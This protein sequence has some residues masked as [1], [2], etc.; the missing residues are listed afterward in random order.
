MRPLLLCA[1]LLALCAAPALAQGRRRTAAEPSAA[2]RRPASRVVPART[3]PA[4]EVPEFE[5]ECPLRD[6]VFADAFQCD[7]YYEC[8]DYVITE[9]LCPD[10]LVFNDISPTLGR[11]DQ[12]FS[13]NCTGREE[14]QEAQPTGDCPRQ[15]G[16]YA[17]PDPTNCGTF[18][19]CV[20]GVSNRV[21]CPSGLV[22]SLQM[23]TC[24]W[25]DQ[26]GRTGCSSAEV[27]AFECPG[28]GDP[29]LAGVPADLPLHPRYA[30]P[31][32]CQFFF[33][34]LDG[35]VPRRHGCEQ[36]RVF[37]DETK[38]CDKP[39]NVPECNY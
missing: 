27:L 22:F 26:A 39:E 2:R 38:Q 17:D 32:D 9:K 33:S 8:R 30:D 13:V 12:V 37:N 1:S 11:C 31:A 36:G 23:G 35:V 5:S 24:Q 3:T 25:P 19:H 20:D 7:R 15:N 18:I 16:Y 34:C 21:E 4:P 28:A 10:G 14:L 29:R 6:G